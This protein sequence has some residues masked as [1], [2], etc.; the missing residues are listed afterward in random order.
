MK[1]KIINAVILVLTSVFLITIFW[2]V[3]RPASIKAR[4]ED[5]CLHK[6]NPPL[7]T[8]QLPLKEECYKSCLSRY[9]VKYDLPK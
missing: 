3:Y 1:K 7:K 5:E 6:F 8:E 2:Y 9:G 4:C